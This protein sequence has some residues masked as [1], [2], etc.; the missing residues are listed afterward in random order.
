MV[1]FAPEAETE[2]VVRAP[3]L[4]VQAVELKKSV[5]SGVSEKAAQQVITRAM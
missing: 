3:Q 1:P 2:L 5:V 4:R